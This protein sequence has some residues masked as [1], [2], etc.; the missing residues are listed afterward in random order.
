MYFNMSVSRFDS[1]LVKMN[2]DV[3]PVWPFLLFDLLQVW[4]ILAQTKA[5][6]H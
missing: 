4:D 5:I 2:T 3:F 1:G 6:T